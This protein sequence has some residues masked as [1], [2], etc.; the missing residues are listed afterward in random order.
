MPDM[1][2]MIHIV[3]TAMHPRWVATITVAKRAGDAA[4]LRE[5]HG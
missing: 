3:T 4:C 5:E 1:A 2:L